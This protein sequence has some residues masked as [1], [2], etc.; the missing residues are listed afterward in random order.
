M[1]AHWQQEKERIGTI[2][3]LKAQIEEVA[4]RVRAGRA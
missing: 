3:E 1:T 4:E 2:R